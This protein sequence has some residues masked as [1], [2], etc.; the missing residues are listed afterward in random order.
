MASDVPIRRVRWPRPRVGGRAWLLTLTRWSSAI[1]FASFG[2]GKFLN[3][4]SE[5]S[6]FSGYGLPAPGAFTY[7]IGVLELGGAA[8]LLLGFRTRLAALALAGDMVGAIVVSGI[9]K[10][11]LVSLTLA[12]VLLVAM[13]AVLVFG[14]GALAID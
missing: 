10:G 9:A 11:E 13:I 3:H 14:A 8:M 12:P 2:A 1:V 6:S 7:A 4:A 5:A